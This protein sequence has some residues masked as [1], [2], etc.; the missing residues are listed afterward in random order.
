MKKYKLNTL[1][2]EWQEY[3]RKRL[4][5]EFEYFINDGF[6]DKKTW[7]NQKGVKICYFLKEAYTKD[8]DE[9]KDSP[10]CTLNWIRQ[11]IQNDG[12]KRMWKKVAIWTHAIKQAE[13]LETPIYN[14]KEI[15]ENYKE[16]TCEIAFVNIKKSNGESHSCFEELMALVND[17]QTAEFLK[18]ELEI[19]NPDVIICGNTF[20]CL[21][22]ILG[23]EITG[24]SSNEKYFAFWKDKIVI[25]YYHPAAY[26]SNI[27]NFYALT[28]IFKAAREK[29]NH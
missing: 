2:Q 28:A 26:T 5:N 14:C 3:E 8:Y 9:N 24:E 16:I 27:V 23:D 10:D 12:P 15:E 18:K 19:I 6:I 4:G 20:S 11:C 21:Q 1:L 22:K 25:N 7:D 29:L 13:L 17:T